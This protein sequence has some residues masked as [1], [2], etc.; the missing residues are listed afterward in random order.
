MITFLFTWWWAKHMSC[1]QSIDRDLVLY[2]W[3]QSRM[4]CM[5][6]WRG[7]WR[8]CFFFVI[9]TFNKEDLY[10]CF[11]SIYDLFNFCKPKKLRIFIE[12]DIP[13]LHGLFIN[14][15]IICSLLIILFKMLN[16][17]RA[18][19][20]FFLVILSSPVTDTYEMLNNLVILIELINIVHGF[21][22][23]L[24]A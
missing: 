10:W 4:W 24:N 19:I 18:G 20:M 1:L 16:L 9:F 11:V 5:W 17:K 6:R 7:S 21:P 13:L 23:F 15:V 22:L 8:H 12:H 2:K 14:C 3:G